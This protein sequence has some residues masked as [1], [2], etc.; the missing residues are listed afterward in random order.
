VTLCEVVIFRLS[1]VVNRA[2]RSYLSGVPLFSTSV[3]PALS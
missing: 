3:V 2:G 1:V